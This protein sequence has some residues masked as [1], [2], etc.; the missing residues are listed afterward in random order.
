MVKL[1]ENQIKQIELLCKQHQMIGLSVFV[2]AARNN[3]TENSDI[4]FLVQFS[5]SVE[6]LNYA[7]NYFELKEKLQK[8]FDREVDLVS[9]KA[10]KNKVLIEEINKSKI[11]L[12][13]A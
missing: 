2:S 6:S 13:A 8:L 5:E 9:I 3:M 10:L 1:I 7:D 12:Y 11:V 4:D